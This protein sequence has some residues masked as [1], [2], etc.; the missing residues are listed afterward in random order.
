MRGNGSYKIVLVLRTLFWLG[1][2]VIHFSQKR[3]TALM[4]LA[5]MLQNVELINIEQPAKTA[6]SNF[7]RFSRYSSIKWCPK[8]ALYLENRKCYGKCDLIFG[9]YE[10][11]SLSF[12]VIRFALFLYLQGENLTRTRPIL[13]AFFI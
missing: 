10:E 11:L 5:K 13:S 3:L 6:C 4:I 7:A 9:I 8:I 1:L 12:C 2:L